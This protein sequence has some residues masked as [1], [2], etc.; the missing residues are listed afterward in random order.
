MA[1]LSIRL[2]GTYRVALDGDPVTAFQSNKVRALLAYLAVESERPH[3][4]ERLAGLFWPERTE[5]SAR[6]NLSQALFDLRR[7]IGD[8]DATPPYLLATPQTIQFNRAS[9]HCLDVRTFTDLLVACKVHPHTRLE[10]CD[11]CME[12]LHKAGDL[13]K[14]DFLAGFSLADSPAFEEWALLE[15]ERMGRMVTDALLQLAG[16]HEE[17]GEYESALG[18]ARR[19]LELDPLLEAAHRQVMRL[20]VYRGERGAALA[21]YEACRQI[22]EDELGGEPAPET[23]ALYEQIQTSEIATPTEAA[24]SPPHNL[25]HHPTPFVGRKTELV[26][27]GK[28]LA[29]PDVQLVTV[30][31][32]GG[33]GKTRLALEAATAQLGAFEHGVFF[34]SLAPLRS[35]DGIVPAVAD[36]LGFTF[37][38]GGEPRQQLLDYLRRKRL[39]LLMDNFEH[40][41]E[42]AGLISDVLKTAPDV[43]VLVTSRARLNLQGEQLYPLAGMEHPKWETPE[44]AAQYSAVELFLLGARRVRPGFEL[45][46]DDLTYLT[47]ICRLVGGMPLGILLAAG[48]VDML[49]PARIA[50]EITHSLDFLETELQDVPERQRSIRAV[51]DHSWSLLAERDKEVL[52]G[53]SVFRGG[54]TPEAAV[55]VTGASLRLLRGLVNKS[56]IAPTSE[57]RYEVHELLRQYVQEKVEA[58]PDGG[59]AA[60]HRHCAYYAAALERWGADMKGA[61]QQAALAEMRADQGNTRAAWDWA[62]E[63][64]QVARL[65]QAVEGLCLFYDRRGRLQEGEAAC[66][67]AVDRLTAIAPGEG[68]AVLQSDAERLRVLAKILTWQGRFNRALGRR[69]PAR[70]LVRQSLAVL[71]KPE[72]AD[73]DTRAERVQA[74][75]LMGSIVLDFGDREE[76]KRLDEESLALHRALGDDWSVARALGGVAELALSSGAYDEAKRWAE[77]SLALRR[78]FGDHWGVANSLGILG[79]CALEQGQLDE[80]ERLIR[81][82]VAIRQRIGH[83]GHEF[84]VSRFL[85][86]RTLIQGGKFPEGRA[87]VQET[88]SL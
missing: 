47:R 56:L 80:A 64:G 1:R 10:A 30:V 87:A 53:L 69:E 3:R 5:S 88:L 78:A 23:T 11:R 17:R 74:L 32:P 24:A 31:G 81:E 45:Q 76:R 67:M 27:L 62:V 60:R 21:Q 79:S 48:W 38:E 86:A 28:L 20:L 85:L 4:R 84:W 34:V 37:Y 82:S 44:D 54:F 25:P 77:E 2:F 22:L 26:E 75:D 16:G 83:R 66:H 72:L 52:Q 42:G 43:K 57:G 68:T 50:A 12:Q 8:R 40:L 15:R 13:Y 18:H 70:Q 51:F 46:D 6:Q 49:S 36:A 71:E 7:V 39:L 35:V 19:L 29:E 41:L 59:K 65:D 9:D 33:M 63:R 14:G 58:S 61:R 73:Q 55:A